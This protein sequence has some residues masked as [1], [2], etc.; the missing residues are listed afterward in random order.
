MTGKAVVR[1]KLE[2]PLIFYLLFQAAEAGYKLV[3]FRG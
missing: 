1:D 3:A 2:G